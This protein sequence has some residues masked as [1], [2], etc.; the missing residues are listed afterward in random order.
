[1][2]AHNFRMDYVH[3]AHGTLGP[4]DPF[5]PVSRFPI[6]LRESL[7]S[8]PR[9]AMSRHESTE[10]I[11]GFFVWGGDSWEI[12][13]FLQR[14]QVWLLLEVQVA[15]APAYGPAVLRLVDT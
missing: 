6:A 10:P 15:L 7:K 12:V 8:D 11:C 2:I 13:G 5:V 14:Q 3:N 1:M 4:F 9:S